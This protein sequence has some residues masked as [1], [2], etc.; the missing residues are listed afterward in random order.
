MSMHVEGSLP[1]LH[2]DVHGIQDHGYTA[3]GPLT[4]NDL[5]AGPKDVG[6]LSVDWLFL[7]GTGN[8]WDKALEM[9]PIIRRVVT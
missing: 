2:R 4:I 8:P 5:A 1:F 7:K 9:I 3:Y 6:K